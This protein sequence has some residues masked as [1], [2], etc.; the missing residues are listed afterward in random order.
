MKQISIIIPCRNAE[1]YI[2]ATLAS[3]LAQRDVD[4][5]VVLID[6]GSTDRSNDIARDMN[7]ARIRIVPGP[8]RGISAAFNAGLDAAS[9]ENVARCDADDLYP[10]DRLAWQ[11]KF[12]ND[13]PAFG[14]VCGYFS[15][16]TSA[17][18]HVADAYFNEPAQEITD[19]LRSG[20]GRSHMCAYTFRTVLLRQIG[21]CRE[22]FLTSEDRDL[23]YRLAE[24]TRVWFEPKS[25]YLYRLHDQSVTHTQKLAARGF[26]EQMAKRF[27]VQRREQGVDDLQNGTPPP[28]HISGVRQTPQSANQQI[29]NIL[30]GQ[31]WKQHGAGIKRAAI[32]VGWRACLAYPTNPGAWKSLL[33]LLLKS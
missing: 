1:R 19:E 17:G 31:A 20:V 8:Q 18:R 32:A 21:G 13:H 30:L 29:Q 24:V 23:Q 5:E 10:P 2:R 9:G 15:T 27:Q 22:W 7:D 6:D 12:L 3:I 25:S 28:V 26:Y 14:A 4:L 11:V 33:A 16:I